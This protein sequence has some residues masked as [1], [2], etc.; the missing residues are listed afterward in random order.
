MRSVGIFGI[1]ST[2][3]GAAS[4]GL[5]TLMCDASRQALEDAGGV[6]PVDAVVAANMGAVRVNRMSGIASALADRLCLVPAAPDT[7]ENGSASGASAFKMGVLAVASGH[8]DVVLVCGGEK[9]RDLG[10]AE[11]TDFIATVSHRYT[12]YIYGATLPSLAAL[13]TRLHMQAY[14]VTREDLARVAVK[15]HANAA[16]N[17]RAHLRKVVTLD[18]IV[19]GSRNPIVADPLRLFDCCPVSDGAA[20][21]L[22]APLDRRADFE[23]PPIEVAG[24]GHASA[25]HAAHSRPDM[26]SLSAVAEASRRAFD[27]AGLGPEDVDIAELHDAFTILEIAQSEVIGFFER[28]KGHLALRSGESQRDARLPINPSGGLKARGH[29]LGATGVSQ[30]VEVARQLREEAGAYQ[31]ARPPEIGFALNLGGFS[32]NALATV[33][34]RVG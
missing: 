5:L 29:P 28:G 21:L 1:G 19:H 10:A 11:A 16:L 18:E 2:A 23:R 32:T 34:R 9:M 26:L 15:N 27:R 24:V 17:P 8:Y 31:I 4:G 30:V 20:A 12:E 7:V 33:L 6:R 25:P 14:G 22:L 13:F 3:F